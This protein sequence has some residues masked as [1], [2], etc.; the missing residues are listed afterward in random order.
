MPSPPAS[1]IP[2]PAKPVRESIS[3]YA[4]LALPTDANGFGNVTGR[5]G[6]A[7]GRSG[8]R[9]GRH[10]TCAET[11]RNRGRGQPA[12]PASRPHWRS[13]HPALLRQPRLPHIHGSGGNR[14]DREPDDRRKTAHLLR[15]PDVRGAG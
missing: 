6:H 8:G 7:P 3:E 5:Q 12:I 14:G 10:E 2:L 4:E 9:H 1:E 11:H 15:L 13:D